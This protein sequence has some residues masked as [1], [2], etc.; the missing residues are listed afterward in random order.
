MIAAFGL[1][2]AVLVPFMPNTTLL[3]R[4]T[5]IPSIAVLP[6][7]EVGAK[8][9]RG[10]FGGGLAEDLTVSLGK[11]SELFVVAQ[12]SAR[13]FSSIDA[14]QAVGRDLGA[15]YLVKGS[16]RRADDRLRVMAEL[17]EAASGRVVWA[18]QYDSPGAD[19]FKLEDQVAGKI[20]STLVAHV[21]RSELDRVSRTRAANLNAY[22]LYL[23]GSA[24]LRARNG[25][26]RG[27]MVHSARGLFE[28][29]LNLDPSY[30][31]AL[32]GLAYTYAVGFLESAEYESGTREFRRIEILDHALSL[33]RKSL[34]L[35]PYRAETHAT[36]A[37]VLH[38]L[39]RRNEAQSE[40]ERALGLNPNLADGRFTHMLVHDGRADEGIAYM[41]RAMSHDPFPPPIYL[42]Y[43]GNAYY[44]TGRY[45]LA[46]RTLKDGFDAV[47]GY[48]P[49]AVWLAASLG[50]LGRA[51]EARPLVEQVLKDAPSFSTKAWLEH[52]RFANPDDAGRLEAGM[53]SAGFPE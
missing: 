39:Y 30:A 24:T 34:E 43:L 10:N 26:H 36:A 2:L 35:D 42:S 13:R 12:G 25:P 32:D 16:I 4:R 50:R 40:I 11:F 33:V 41:Q 27:Q 18:Q 22:D 48:R 3:S 52:V 19:L 38:W 5:E 21:S 8:A 1:L 28:Q 37:W 9:Q 7:D 49:L 15:R 31:P 17:I 45:D 46:Y 20:A 29:A 44:E 51:E 6:F 47:P 23:E 53:K 14:P